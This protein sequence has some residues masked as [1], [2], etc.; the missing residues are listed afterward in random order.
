VAERGEETVDEIG[1]VSSLMGGSVDREVGS[2]EDSVGLQLIQPRPVCTGVVYD[3][4]VRRGLAQCDDCQAEVGE[5]RAPG[6]IL[7]GSKSWAVLPDLRFQAAA[8]YWLMSPPRTDRR[9]IL[10]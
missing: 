10:P 5:R 4:A 7:S 8:S 1:D 2:D 6:R 9:R 3:D